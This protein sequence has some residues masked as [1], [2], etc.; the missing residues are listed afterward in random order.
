M[1][2]ALDA[3]LAAVE[4]LLGERGPAPWA[5]ADL[6]GFDPAQLRLAD[7]AADLGHFD[8]AALAVTRHQLASVARCLTRLHADIDAIQTRRVRDDLSTRGRER[9]ALVPDWERIRVIL[10][11]QAV[12]WLVAL[13][14]LYVPDI[15]LG[16]MALV[17]ATSISMML[18]I[19][20]QFRPLTLIPPLLSAMVFGTWIIPA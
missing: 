19:L 6:V 13:M 7:D 9:R 4:A 18:V 17:I 3:R 11:Q 1:A 20:P 16:E 8:R 15:P 14:V 5:D 2:A 12:F 10:R